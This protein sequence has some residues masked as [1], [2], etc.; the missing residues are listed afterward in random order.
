[1]STDEVRSFAHYICKFNEGERSGIRVIQPITETAG[2]AAPIG[3]YPEHW[4]DSW[5][6]L[7]GANDLYGAR[8]QCGVTLLQAEMIGLSYKSGYETAWDDVSNENLVPDFVHA[9]RA[10]DI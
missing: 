2:G 6:D 9:A 10:V 3:E 7:E 1:M 4:V 8:P 5:H